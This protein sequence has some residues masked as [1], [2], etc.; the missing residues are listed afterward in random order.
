MLLTA[1]SHTSCFY[2]NNNNNNMWTYPG[3]VHYQ[4]W[5]GPLS[6]LMRALDYNAVDWG[7]TLNVDLPDIWCCL[8]LDHTHHVSTNVLVLV[9][10]CL[11][12]FD[13][14]SIAS[15]RRRALSLH[16]P[17][18]HTNCYQTQTWETCWISPKKQG[19]TTTH[20]LIWYASAA[21]IFGVQAYTQFVSPKMSRQ[22]IK[23]IYV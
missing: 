11:Y 6:S 20:A 19:A 10:D 2:N 21:H 13:T 17:L 9:Q 18:S 12:V 1:W 5:I 4:S 15:R 16:E 14:R 22:H 7:T 8:L 3:L 23:L